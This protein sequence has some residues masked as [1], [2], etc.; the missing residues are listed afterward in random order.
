MIYCML[1]KN[2]QAL[3][4]YNKAE[5]HLLYAIAILPERIYP[6]YLLVKLYSEPKFYHPDKRQQAA[7]SVLTKNP[8]VDSRA[9]EEMKEK[10]LHNTQIWRK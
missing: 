10:V 6:Y 2:E 9:V 8:K 5:T 4:E 1:A 7:R 3:G